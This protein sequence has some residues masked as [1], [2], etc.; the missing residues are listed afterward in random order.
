MMRQPLQ[1]E[2]EFPMADSVPMLGSGHQWKPEDEFS[3]QKRCAKSLKGTSALSRT[4]PFMASS[5]C[6]W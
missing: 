6:A 3:T 5:R 4:R 1:G 2:I